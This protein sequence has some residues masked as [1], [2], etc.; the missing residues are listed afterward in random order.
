MTDINSADLGQAIEQDGLAIVRD[1]L[2]PGDVVVVT[3]AE[4]G[5]MHCDMVS[6]DDIKAAAAA[7]LD[8]FGLCVRTLWL[9]TVPAF[10]PPPRRFPC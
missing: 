10:R 9:L 3:G 1:C 8:R 5:F 6:A 4:T 7:V 2:K